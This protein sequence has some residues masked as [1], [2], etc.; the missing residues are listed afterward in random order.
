MAYLIE[1]ACGCNKGRI[2]RNNED[3][4]LFA[5]QCLPMENDGLESPI[6]VLSSLCH[7]RIMAVFDGM[8][9]ENF[10]EAASFT[11]ADCMKKAEKRLWDYFIPERRRLLTLSNNLNVAV[12]NAAEERHTER[13]GTTFVTLRF[14]RQY[15]HI[16]NL[17]DSRAYRLRNGELIQL[18]EDHVETP[19]RP[20]DIGRK[21]PLT[22]HL[23]IDPEYYLLEPHIAKSRLCSG[24]QYLLCSDGL[25]DMLT[26]EEIKAVLLAE[27]SAEVCVDQLIRRAL[28]NGGRDNITA[29]VCRIT[30][31]RDKKEGIYGKD[32]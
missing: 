8:G 26:D 25:T 30:C 27:E 16:C 4:F 19:R 7:E 23:G 9:G 13:M 28:K 14:L 32:V 2:R 10:G 18:S 6:A 17:G 29:I 21:M 1:A 12:V 24:D 31:K 11:A 20:E 15:V 5:G 22:Q 3:N